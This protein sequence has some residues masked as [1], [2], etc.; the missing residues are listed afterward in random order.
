MTALIPIRGRYRWFLAA[1]LLAGAAS[2]SPAAELPVEKF[3]V[4]LARACLPNVNVNDALA[5]YRVLL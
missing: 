5:A 3:E 2:A 1:V 4:G